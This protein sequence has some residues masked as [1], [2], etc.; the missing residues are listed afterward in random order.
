MNSVGKGKVHRSR[1]VHGRRVQACDENKF[2]DEMMPVE[3]EV[4]SPDFDRLIEVGHRAGAAGF[5][6]LILAGGETGI[7]PAHPGRRACPRGCPTKAEEV[8]ADR[9]CPDD[10]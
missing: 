4:G 2:W 10:G 5:A 8:L 3:R 9:H 7:R 1:A 6:P